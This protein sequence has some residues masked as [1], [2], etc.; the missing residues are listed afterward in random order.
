MAG[1]TAY[2]SRPGPAPPGRLSR[3][4]RCRRLCLSG[5]YRPFANL[6]RIATIGWVLRFYIISLPGAEGR[7][8]FIIGTKRE[9]RVRDRSV[10]HGMRFQVELLVGLSELAGLRSFFFLSPL[11]P[12][13]SSLAFSLPSVSNGS[14]GLLLGFLASVA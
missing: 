10:L 8:A 2:P 6:Q 7:Q 11:P 5:S 14:D 9:G 13:L 4:P 3:R 12:I 1:R